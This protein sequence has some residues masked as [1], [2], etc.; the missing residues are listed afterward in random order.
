MV[1]GAAVAIVVVIDDDEQ[2]RRAIERILVRRGHDVITAQD[3]HEALR[4]TSHCSPDLIITDIYM[5]ECD[6]FE[7]ITLLRATRGH[8]PIIAMSAGQLEGLDVL[9]VAGRLGAQVKLPKPFN[10]TQFLAAVDQA[11]AATGPGTS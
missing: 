11:F 9:G 8:V 6:G 2:M 3:G 4:R 10:E 7:L 5:P 1:R